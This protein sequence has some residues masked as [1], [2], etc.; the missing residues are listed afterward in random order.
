MP[1]V[2][3]LCEY[4]TLNGGERSM[5]A[6]L[7]GISRAGYDVRIAAPASG[8]LADAARLAGI[9]L[10]V[11]DSRDSQG[12]PLGLDE[13][14]RRLAEILRYQRPS[15][16]HAN[17]VAMGRL[18]G[19]VATEL[20]LPSLAHLR[21]IVGLSE[22]A[23]ADLNCHACLLAVSEATRRFHM[24]QGI[25]GERTFVLHNGIDIV[26]FR[27]RP[28]GGYLHAELGLSPGLPLI[29]TIG[30]ISLRKG[31]DVLAAALAEIADELPFAWLIVGERFSEKEESREFEARLRAV[32]AG[33]LAGR[34]RFLGRRGDVDRILNELTLLVH[35]ARQE[36]L[37][38][39]LLEAAAAG[40]AIVATDVGGTAEIFPPSGEA[41][42]L[43]P[44]D[45][46]TALACAVQSLLAD[47]GRR[48]RL[49]AA[50][51]ERAVTAFDREMA[52]AKL[53]EHY[54][55]VQTS[56]IRPTGC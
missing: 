1:A 51:R 30:Q 50:A 17:S 49:A 4:G 14:R 47:Q 40:T 3:I 11:F 52:V 54:D 34:V 45:D 15:L 24:T 43:V 8:P 42:W 31:Q 27:P 39:V 46:A 48:L 6:T 55:R 12:L 21:D 41:A 44:C 23:R 37:G 20:G 2:L 19:P 16:L 35:P 5:L 28:P 13:R 38:R 25:D 36:P 10:V 9:D 32:A 26:Q 7:D 18:S 22:R 56:R 53:L 33:P 29:G